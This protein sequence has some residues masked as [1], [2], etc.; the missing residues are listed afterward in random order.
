MIRA[1]TASGALRAW[2]AVGMVVVA[3]VL[4]SGIGIAYTAVTQ[5]QADR[6]W[7]SLL[8]TL[9]SPGVPRP[10]TPRGVQIQDRIHALSVELGC[11]PRTARTP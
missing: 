8:L 5:R 9:D 7:C 1:L 3:A 6:R 4:V 2:W 11:S 10:T